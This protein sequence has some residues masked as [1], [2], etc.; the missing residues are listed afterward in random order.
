MLLNPGEEC[1]T[2]GEVEVWTEVLSC[3]QLQANLSPFDMDQAQEYL[4]Q[5]SVT[6]SELN[7]VS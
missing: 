2:E 5:I 7:K 1:S 6:K 3:L 4:K